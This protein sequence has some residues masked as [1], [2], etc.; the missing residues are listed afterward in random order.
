MLS[1]RIRLPLFKA[2]TG[3]RALSTSADEANAAIQRLADMTLFPQLSSN[4]QSVSTK[5]RLVDIGP[6]AAI[7][8]VQ[9]ISPHHLTR[10][11]R[12]IRT[13]RRRKDPTLGPFRKHAEA[14]DAFRKLNID[15]LDEFKNALLLKA[16]VTEMGKIQPRSKT[17][18]TQRSQRRVGKAIRRARAMGL[19]PLWNAPDPTDGRRFLPDWTS[20]AKR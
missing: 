14:I 18:L 4:S 20:L 12:I 15:P 16:F 10:E 2:C 13:E 6:L 17:G 5:T 19:I 3:L 8:L 9:F 11:H 1:L 7:D